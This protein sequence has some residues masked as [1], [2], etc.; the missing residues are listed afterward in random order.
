MGIV[1]HANHLNYFELARSAWIRENW[2]PYKEIEESGFGFVVTNAQLKY[3]SP[4]YYD[5]EIEVSAILCEVGKSRIAFQYEIS[6][7]EGKLLLCTGF[8]ELCYIN[9]LRKPV[10][11]PDEMRVII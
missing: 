1:Y 11:I 10:R 5:D 3:I 7:I 2:K 4:I 8:T 9:N 6:R